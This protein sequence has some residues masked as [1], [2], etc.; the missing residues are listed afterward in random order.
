VRYLARRLTG[1]RAWLD[2]LPLGGVE[3]TRVLSGP[4][5]ITATI[6]PEL[7]EVVAADGFRVIEDWRTIIY[8]V[9]DELPGSPIVGHGIV[10]PPTSWEEAATTLNCAGVAAYPQGMVFGES[11]I[12][13]PEPPMHGDVSKPEVPRPDPLQIVQDLW[14][15]LQAQDDSDLGVVL[16]GDLASSVRIGDYEEPYRLRW[17]EAPDIGN[18][19][20]NLAQYTPFDFVEEAH[21]TDATMTDVVHS[22]RLGWPRLGRRREDLRFVLNENIVSS[23]PA[24]SLDTYANDVVGIGNGEGSTMVMARS[25]VRD[26]RLRRTKV[27][28]DKTMKQYELN[29][30][31]VMARE[32]VAAGPDIASIR[33]KEHDNAPLASINPGDDIYIQTTIPAYGK[34]NQWSRVLGIG[35]IDNSDEAVLALKRSGAFI[36]SPTSEADL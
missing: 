12:W 31:T 8:A 24:E 23:D 14:A 13:G 4:G 1:D 32:R 33:V 17:W 21:W 34:I 26:G 35:Q 15:Y 22:I 9:D 5:T 36:Y 18:E 29:R 6:E 20:D 3:R 7:R 10:L 28:T 25:T 19:I 30:F 16:T 27:V 2:D 11:R